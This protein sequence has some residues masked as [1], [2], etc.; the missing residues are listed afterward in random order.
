MSYGL[1]LLSQL[2][3]EREGQRKMEREREREKGKIN[4]MYWSI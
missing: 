3:R 1:V 2:V 4:E